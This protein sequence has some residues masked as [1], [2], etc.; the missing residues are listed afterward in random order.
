MFVFFGEMRDLL[1]PAMFQGSGA[2]AGSWDMGWAKAGSW[3][4]SSHPPIR[5]G[6]IRGSQG[7]LTH[8]GWPTAMTAFSLCREGGKI[9]KKRLLNASQ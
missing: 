9:R 4:H 6:S 8:P 7:K 3:P 2:E 1:L 5:V